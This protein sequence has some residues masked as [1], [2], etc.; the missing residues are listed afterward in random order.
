MSDD[1]A[2]WRSGAGL[3]II[4][5]F[6]T[7]LVSGVSTFVNTWAVRG[8]VSDPFVTARNVLVVLLLVP[9]VLLARPG[10]A[11]RL[12]R[13]D[14]ARLAAIGILGGG[15]PFVLYFR[16]LQ[17][18][19]AG[20]ITG[21]FLFRLL[22]IPATALAVIFLGERPKRWLLLAAGLL[23]VGVVLLTP[24]GGW[25]DAT[26]LMLAATVLWSAE[27]TLSKRTLRD[28]PAGTVAL[29]RMGFGV[30]FLLG[31]LTVTGQVGGL[32]AFGAPQL[33]WIALSAV[34]LVGFVWTWYSGL[35]RVDLSTAT[36]VL[37]LGFPIS[38]ALRALVGR[39][40]FD[41][42]H[43]AGAIAVVLGVGAAVGLAALRESF[44]P[45]PRMVLAR[46]RRTAGR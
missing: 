38:W 27:Y 7:A 8:T 15:I 46:L 37:V 18:A 39:E 29:G 22:F 5:V 4:L 42:G 41:S 43:A 34:L 31:Y 14:W 6:L 13:T 9:L 11:V 25:T 36:A 32:L 30:V 17:I 21:S 20:V 28:L 24:V 3:G 23:V 19:G 35:K 16:G 33:P 1:G 12:R 44:R 40:T 2:R 26:S 10:P 45:L